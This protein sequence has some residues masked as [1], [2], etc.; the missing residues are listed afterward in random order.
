MHT[1]STY[2]VPESY[3]CYNETNKNIQVKYSQS[4]FAMLVVRLLTGCMD[5]RFIKKHAHTH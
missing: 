1:Q 4:I 5:S 3:T 2:I